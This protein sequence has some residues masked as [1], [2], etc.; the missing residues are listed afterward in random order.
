MLTPVLSCIEIYFVSVAASLAL[1]MI[2]MAY[3]WIAPVLP[4]LLG[5]NSEIKMTADESSWVVVFIE[6]GCLFTPIPVG[7]LMDK[8]GRKPMFISCAPVFV[9]SWLLKITTRS[10]MILYVVR[11]FEGLALGCVFTLAPVYIG[12]IAEPSVRSKLSNMQSVMWYIGILSEDCVGP[13]LSYSA[14]AWFSITVPILFFACFLVL[15][16]TPFYL[17]IRGKEGKAAQALAW[18]RGG[19]PEPHIADELQA[20]KDHIHEE[21]LNKKS[22]TAI[23]TDDVYLKSIYVIT[24]IVFSTFLSGLTTV[25][26]FSTQIFSKTAGTCLTADHY[27]IIIGCVF[28]LMTFVTAS[29]VD[30]FG[31]RPLILLS[32]CGCFLSNLLTGLYYYF[33]DENSG[34]HSFIPF[35]TIGFYVISVS[36][37]LAPLTATYQGE[38]FPPGIRGAA[39]GYTAISRTLFSLICLK[40]Y[41]LIQ[42]TIG[43]YANYF[44]FAFSAGLGAIMLYIHLPE[45]KGKTLVEIHKEM[46]GRMYKARDLNDTSELETFS[47]VEL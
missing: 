39:S 17:V 42:R 36:L 45:T 7:L 1:M 16:E 47:P 40:L 18:F 3:G 10:L 30:R 38:L 11:L 44:L 24:V 32:V 41:T 35:V 20:I 9:I 34:H 19:V 12:E 28:V 21:K 25:Y 22:W 14:L 43:L 23:F 5:D 37:G 29:V 33:Y 26:A 4:R 31:R 27:T 15:P 13:Y 8:Y 6:V 2:G 46:K